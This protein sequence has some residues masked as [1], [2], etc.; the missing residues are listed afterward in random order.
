MEYLVFSSFAV[1]TISLL[2]PHPTHHINFL[3]SHFH[4][5]LL[6]SVRLETSDKN[7]VL[8]SSFQCKVPILRSLITSA[9][10][11]LPNEA[12]YSQVLKIKIWLAAFCMYIYFGMH[13]CV[14][15]DS[16][17]EDAIWT[18]N[19]LKMRSVAIKPE[20]LKLW[21]CHWLNWGNIQHFC[22]IRISTLC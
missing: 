7:R 15:I 22:K 8:R 6:T 12:K 18:K 11:I 9:K 17:T 20:P 21:N 13:V 5:P 2:S 4:V 3:L 19:L 14:F 1:P 10:L 16:S